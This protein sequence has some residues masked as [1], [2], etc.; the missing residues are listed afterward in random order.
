MVSLLPNRA[1]FAVAIGL[2]LAP[3]AVHAERLLGP[4]S[5]FTRGA[6]QSGAGIAAR[7]L[8]EDGIGLVV[9]AVHA[10]AAGSGDAAAQL[11]LITPIRGHGI[12]LRPY[13]AIGPALEWDN[14]QRGPR[15]S[16]TGVIDIGVMTRPWR[17]RAWLSLSA[18][19]RA[20]G[21]SDVAPWSARAGLMVGF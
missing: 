16:A 1:A 9:T 11:M 14:A 21:D 17:G 15:R 20:L 3:A 7:L 2:A 4:A 6:D 13:L 19:W 12:V 10:P 8:R 5:R 18:R